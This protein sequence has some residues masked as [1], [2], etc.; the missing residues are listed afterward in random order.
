MS[1]SDFINQLKELGFHIKEWGN[2]K[3]SF[4]YTVPAGKFIGREIVLGFDI[5][6]DFPN[7]PPGGPHLTP[8]LLPLNPEAPSHPQRV[9]TSNFG[10]DWEYWSRPFPGWAESDHSVKLYMAHIV[11][12]FET[13]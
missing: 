12:L 7:S 8:P 2:N 3:V 4:P 1:T 10:T 13:Q 11:N 6:G 9:H 5:P